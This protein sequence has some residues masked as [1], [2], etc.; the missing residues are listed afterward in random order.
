M[1]KRRQPY[2]P[3][4]RKAGAGS[5]G[6][7]E[8]EAAYADSIFRTATGDVKGAIVALRRALEFAPRYAP[9]IF[10]LGTVKYQRGNRAEG[11]RLFHSLLS[12]QND[13]PDLVGLIDHA[14]DFLI[15]LAAY[16]DGLDLYRAAA[17]RFPDVAVF[18]QGVGCCAGHR[19]L[20]EQAVDASRRALEL[21]PGN[22]K[23]VNDLGW[24][25]LEAGRLP[26][27]EETLARAVAMD[28]GDERACEN[29]RFCKTKLAKEAATPNMAC[30]RRRPV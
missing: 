1:A 12:Y 24:S 16:E 13:T 11:R 29:L 27:A 21:E 22:Q 7:F 5:W 17:L 8:A 6:L 14:G 3:A 4:G 23:L 2:Q 30:S 28:P 10:S 19:G 20:H 26:E 18:H 9:A 25:L 15:G